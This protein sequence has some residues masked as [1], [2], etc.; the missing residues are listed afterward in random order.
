MKW[1]RCWISAFLE[2]PHMD[3]WRGGHRVA[4]VVAMRK[5]S[6]VPVMRHQHGRDRRLYLA[7]VNRGAG[8]GGRR[9]FRHSEQ[10]ETRC[11]AGAPGR[12]LM[13]RWT[14][15]I[16]EAGH[17]VAGVVLS[18]GRVVMTLHEDGGGAAWPLEDLPPTD[19]A[20][21]TAAGPLAEPL[22]ARHAPPEIPVPVSGNE[23][24]VRQP[25]P[26]MESSTTPDAVADIR[27]NLARSPPDHV[28][29][30]RWCIAGVK[31]QPERWAQR[32]AWLQTLAARL[33]RDHEQQI[34]EAARVLYQR[35]VVSVPLRE[36][37]AS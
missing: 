30:A 7:M 13:N 36:R 25:L 9:H 18:G 4:R 17:A 6:S 14:V 33:V 24:S 27:R 16:H 28:A 11:G 19:F 22:A 12:K 2:G 5:V 32:H 35:G 3:A 10:S 20:I 15:A 37:S 34:V 26:T 31:D 21:M 1:D 8:I 29:V 23:P